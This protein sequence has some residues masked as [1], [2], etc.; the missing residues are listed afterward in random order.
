MVFGGNLDLCSGAMVTPIWL[1]HKLCFP[2]RQ[3]LCFTL[4]LLAMLSHMDIPV[5]AQPSGF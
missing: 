2:L 4:C 3:E 5:S 1:R